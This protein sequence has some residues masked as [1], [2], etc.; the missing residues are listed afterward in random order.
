MNDTKLLNLDSITINRN[1]I[2]EEEVVNKKY[3]DENLDSST[4]GLNDDSNEK[5]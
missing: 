1:T 5:F 3:F 2:L 4:I